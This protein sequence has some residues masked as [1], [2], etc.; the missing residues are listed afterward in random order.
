MVGKRNKE[1]EKERNTD[2]KSKMESSSDTKRGNLGSRR[3]YEEQVSPF[4]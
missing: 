1:V 3:A 2:G 4:V